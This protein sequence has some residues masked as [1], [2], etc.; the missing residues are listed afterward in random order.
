MRESKMHKSVR[1][2]ERDL[3]EGTDAPEIEEDL[4]LGY[5]EPRKMLTIFLAISTGFVI[6]MLLN[7]QGT[8]F[9]Y[10]LAELVANVVGLLA[11]QWRNARM[12]LVF[13]LYTVIS[14]LISSLMGIFTATVVLR[15]DVCSNMGR[16]FDRP[17]LVSLC[18]RNQEAFQ[19]VAILAIFSEL[20]LGL[21]VINLVQRTYH[22]FGKHERTTSG[23]GT[24]SI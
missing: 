7:S 17:D 12:L 20:F 1:E 3:L 18:S 6:D 15:R 2:L 9:Y 16:L 5:L 24:I 14:F 8:M 4:V 11:V 13:G 10:S 23:C 21:F 19:I 22:G